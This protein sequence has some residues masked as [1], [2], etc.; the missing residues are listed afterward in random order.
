MKSRKNLPYKLN[1]E[2]NDAQ[3]TQ[4]KLGVAFSYVERNQYATGCL[5]D[6]SQQDSL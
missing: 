2:A 3:N 5:H 6:L 4:D 1:R